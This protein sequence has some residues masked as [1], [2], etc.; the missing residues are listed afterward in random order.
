MHFEPV[1]QA[2]AGVE[3]TDMELAILKKLVEL[4]NGKI[5]FKSA[6]NVSRTFWMEL[7]KSSQ[8]SAP[9]YR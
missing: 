3:G 1:G 6:S 5:A 9:L 4:I 8:E 7:S 2:S